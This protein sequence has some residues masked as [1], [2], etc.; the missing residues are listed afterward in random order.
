MR[1]VG[2]GAGVGNEKA[3]LLLPGLVG[4]CGD[5]SGSGGVVGF[6]KGRLLADGPEFRKRGGGRCGH[7]E[8]LPEQR[9]GQARHRHPAALSL[10]AK[11]AV[12]IVGRYN[13]WG[14]H[15]YPTDLGFVRRAESCRDITEPIL[16]KKPSPILKRKW[17]RTAPDIGGFAEGVQ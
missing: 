5:A 7:G 9:V 2:W 12:H 11:R 13:D 17:E 15:D 16:V 4:D 3:R 14:P 10:A 6:R 1:F 8:R